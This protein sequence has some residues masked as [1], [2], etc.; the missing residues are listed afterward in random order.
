MYDLCDVR[1]AIFHY[2]VGKFVAQFSFGIAH[3]TDT[4]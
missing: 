2:P 1:Q 4:I 3:R